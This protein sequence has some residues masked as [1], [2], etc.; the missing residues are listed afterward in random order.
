MTCALFPTLP[1]FSPC[2]KAISIK[3]YLKLNVSFFFF[4]ASLTLF[5][6]CYSYYNWE[7]AT[8]SE[9]SSWHVCG[10]FDSGGSS[11]VTLEETVFISLA[12]LLVAYLPATPPM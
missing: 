11:G 3:S 10:S 7:K 1:A 6:M 5:F 2:S 4:K 8:G 9:V 12:D